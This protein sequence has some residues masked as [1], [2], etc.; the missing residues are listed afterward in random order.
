VCDDEGFGDMDVDVDWEYSKLL[1]DVPTVLT[2]A[3]SLG[4]D[5]CRFSNVLYS[6]LLLL[7]LLWSAAYLFNDDELNVNDDIDN[8][9]D[10][11]AFSSSASST[12]NC[13]L[14]EYPVALLRVRAL[15]R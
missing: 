14:L 2:F 9:L 1:L 6:V 4:D 10:T 5:V 7:L 11:T 13:L 8:L 15:V 3:F 12:S